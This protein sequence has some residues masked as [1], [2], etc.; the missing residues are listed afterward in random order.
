MISYRHVLTAAHC[1]VDPLEPI[2]VRLGEWDMTKDPD[3]F[4]DHE[5][6]KICSR[7]LDI[8]IKKIDIHE[9]YSKLERNHDIA[10]IHI[11]KKVVPTE[12]IKPICMPF[13]EKFQ[14]EDRRL[15]VAGWG[16]TERNFSSNVLIKAEVIGQNYS[17]CENRFLNVDFMRDSQLC[18]IGENGEDTRSGD[19]GGPL[20]YINRVNFT[21]PIM[22]IVGIT[23][24]GNILGKSDIPSVYTNIGHYKALLEKWIVLS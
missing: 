3:C 12:F 19:S 15:S 10:L 24:Y 7:I 11:S 8:P 4:T 13:D 18:V 20:M 9:K 17:K 6:N 16:L 22:F 21:K 23:A 14:F 5:N 1:V 2:A